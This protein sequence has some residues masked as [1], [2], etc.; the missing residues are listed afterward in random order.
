[1]DL[2]NLFS[3]A[4]RSGMAA[5]LTL[6]AVVLVAGLSVK[7]FVDRTVLADGP[8]TQR[9]IRR[10]AAEQRKALNASDRVPRGSS[11]GGQF[12]PHQRSDAEIG[13]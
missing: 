6:G 12:A 7:R 11:T 2:F 9:D 1:V 5:G 4:A 3:E 13:L 8:A 10:E